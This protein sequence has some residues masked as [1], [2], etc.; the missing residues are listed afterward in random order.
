MKTRRRLTKD[1]I[2]ILFVVIF[3]KSFNKAKSGYILKMDVMHVLMR[4]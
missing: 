2:N 4:K 3:P 1:V